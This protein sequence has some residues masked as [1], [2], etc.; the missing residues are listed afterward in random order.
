MLRLTESQI[1]RVIRQRRVSSFAGLALMALPFALPRGWGVG[2]FSGFMLFSL[3]IYGIAFR[4]WRTEPGLW[5]LAVF[6]T[7][8]LGPCWAYFE[9]LHWRGF[10]AEPAAKQA[11]ARSPGIS[12][13]CP[14]MP[15]SLLCYL[16]MQSNWR[17]QW[18]SKTGSELVS[19]N[20]PL[21]RHRSSV[22]NL[23][24]SES[25]DLVLEMDA[26]TRR[27]LVNAV[28]TSCGTHLA[29]VV[30]NVCCNWR[31]SCSDSDSGSC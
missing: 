31:S 12:C 6:L 14:S 26:L 23:A 30:S 29:D 15:S 9:F 25:R 18:R 28:V 11:A 17:W 5:M 22:S 21:S 7:V 20:G 2:L 4:K 8:T 3:G 27:G 16:R 10:F 24:L 1:D 13:D 19:S